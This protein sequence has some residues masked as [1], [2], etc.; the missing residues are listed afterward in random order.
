[1]FTRAW[2]PGCG[3]VSSAGAVWAASGPHRPGYH[4]GSTSTAERREMPPWASGCIIPTQ[5]ID[6]ST[7]ANQRKP[8]PRQKK[9]PVSPLAALSRSFMSCVTVPVPGTAGSCGLG[10]AHTAP[11]ANAP[12]KKQHLV[13]PGVVLLIPGGSIL[14]MT[15]HSLNVRAAQHVSG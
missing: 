9:P 11:A 10:A 1:M 6:L 13:F 7:Q 12:G 5:Q 15:N 8:F 14:Q 4:R 2:S 3:A